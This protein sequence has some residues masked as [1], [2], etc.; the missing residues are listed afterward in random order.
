MQPRFQR[1]CVEGQAIF[2]GLAAATRQTLEPETDFRHFSRWGSQLL[3]GSSGLAALSMARALGRGR[4]IYDFGP[5][6]S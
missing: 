1:R 4:V 3:R 5:C 2:R 6:H